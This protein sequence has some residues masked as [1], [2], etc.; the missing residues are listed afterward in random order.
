M[1]A[2]DF[3]Q[4]FTD[5]L[6][7]FWGDSVKLVDGAELTWMRQ[8]HY[9]MGLY[10]FTYQAGLTVGTIISDKIV[11]GTEADRKNWL[12][13]LKM[14]G[15]RGPIELAKAAGVDMASPKALSQ[16]IDFIGEIIDQIDELLTELDMYKG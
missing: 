9:Y 10:S 4:I 15:S 16:A 8:P 5:K 11:H 7:E 1:T 14:G 2:D 3:N 6:K 12:E 13:V